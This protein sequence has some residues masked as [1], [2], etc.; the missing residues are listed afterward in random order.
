MN[1]K[2]LALLFLICTASAAFLKRDKEDN[3]IQ[4]LYSIS[5]DD[6]KTI[7]VFKP[8]ETDI[9]HITGALEGLTATR[10]TKRS[11]EASYANSNNNALLGVSQLHDGAVL[12]MFQKSCEVLL[13]I[14]ELSSTVL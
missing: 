3:S 6:S 12:S 14:W 11:N 2:S 10:T 13:L 1:P 7:N 8:K 4:G 5:D 9:A